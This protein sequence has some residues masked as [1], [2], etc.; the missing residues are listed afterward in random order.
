MATN[1]RW[2]VLPRAPFRSHWLL[3]LLSVWLLTLAPS[4]Q[5]ANTLESIDVSALG[6]GGV[7]ITLNLAATAE[8]PK[9]FTIDDPARV[10]LDL[11]ETRNATD[12]RQRTIDIGAVEGL[13]VV[14]AGGRT[15]VVVNLSNPLPHDLL[16]TDN[17]II[18]TLSDTAGAAAPADSSADGERGL[19]GIDFR[20]SPSGAGKI[21]VSLPTAQVVPDVRQEGNRILVDLADTPLP[22]ELA[23]RLDVIDF[24]TPVQFVDATGES[25]GT[26]ITI[27]PT[28]AYEHTVY[29]TDRL[30]TIEVRAK[31]EAEIEAEERDKKEF[32][33]KRL[34]L[35]FQDIEVRSVLQLLADFTG[36]NIVVS[37]SV[38]GN[39]TLRLQNVPWDQALDLILKTRGLSMRQTGNV[40]MIA[41]TEEIAAREK[42]E[43]EAMRQVEDLSPLY[44]EYIQI[45]YAKANSFAELL[46]SEG[47]GLLSE[48][49]NVSVDVRTNTLLV[50]DTAEAL[51]NVRRMVKRLD[52][53]VRQVL[54]ESRVVIASDDFAR[55][56]GVRLGASI[57]QTSNTTTNIIGGGL[58]GDL[59]YPQITGIENPGGSGNES[60]VVDL[61]AA[62]AAGALNFII[63]RIG[64]ELLRLEL[65]AMQAEGR[66]E[67]V[68]SPR[69]ITANQNQAEI[70]QGVEIPYQE[71]AGASGA[72]DT[73]FK[74]ATL[75][76]R[77]TPLIT[78]DNRISLDLEVNK[79]S[80]GQVFNGVPSIDTRRV[81]TNVLVDNGE[82]VVLGGIYEHEKVDS[83]NKVP[84][85]G[86]LPAV[87]WA[88]RQKSRSDTKSEL[89]IFVTPKILDESLSQL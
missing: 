58:A 72:T 11:F 64:S 7:Q 26:R 63:G 74:E 1:N 78:P 82:T 42:L 81:K 88:F 23:Q 15:R 27:H 85:F 8:A 71:S 10:A 34:S 30:L 51:D 62:G 3:V 84:F 75:M 46:K 12:S 17:R 6:R 38:S 18:L 28:G 86:D 67:V 29:Q 52:I 53:P 59:T 89:L 87:G 56:L 44:S 41:P 48:R 57:S 39:L 5:A 50:R 35:N 20:R 16:V 37:D 66:G 31:S 43:L 61:P 24:A 69:V 45:N 65:S 80:V 70:Q 33:G 14:E 76:L 19:Q 60:L 77:V 54:I 68:S 4:S 55:D 40:I 83:L 49:G 32:T 79:D 9:L 73:Q 36:L 2:E 47:G 25:G 13:A 22:P 21:L